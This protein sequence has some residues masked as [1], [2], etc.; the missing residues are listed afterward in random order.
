MEGVVRM[1][2]FTGL[3][4]IPFGAAVAGVQAQQILLAELPN[5]LAT[6][7]L[8]AQQEP[9]APSPQAVEAAQLPATLVLAA[10]ARSS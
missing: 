1:P 7:A 2:W 8:V 10:Q 3:Q 6:A 5:T 4:T 9:Q